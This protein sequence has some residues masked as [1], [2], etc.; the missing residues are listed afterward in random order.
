MDATAVAPAA[1]LVHVAVEAINN[2][3]DGLVRIQFLH[4]VGFVY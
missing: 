4:V 2:N 1:T 3:F